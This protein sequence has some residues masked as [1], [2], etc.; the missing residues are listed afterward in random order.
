MG[1][2]VTDGAIEIRDYRFAVVRGSDH[3]SFPSA[4]NRI[5]D[6]RI[7][8]VFWINRDVEHL[9]LARLAEPLSYDETEWHRTLDQTSGLCRKLANPYVWN[10]IC[11]TSHLPG[12]DYN[13]WNKATG[14]SDAAPD[15]V[16]PEEFQQFN[17]VFVAT[18]WPGFAL[19][20]SESGS[21]LRFTRVCAG[22]AQ[23]LRNSRYV[24][25]PGDCR[26]HQFCV[27]DLPTRVV[28]WHSCG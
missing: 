1:E 21:L 23:M 9:D 28:S 15:F 10:G 4:I 8:D 16:I 24:I 13:E 18:K 2:T 20:D 11:F 26:T 12:R 5:R 14:F 22:D 27:F 17:P 19:E 7:M 6:R 25:S 3:H